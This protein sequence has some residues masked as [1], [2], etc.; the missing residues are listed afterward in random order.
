MLCNSVVL[1]HFEMLEL[2][3]SSNEFPEAC[4]LSP[5]CQASKQA[6]VDQAGQLG[7][8]CTHGNTFSSCLSSVRLVGL[9][10]TTTELPRAH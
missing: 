1:A 5:A 7:E 4:W 6:D 3:M 9:T 2:L 10:C 8:S